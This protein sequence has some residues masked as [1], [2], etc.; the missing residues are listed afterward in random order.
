M[1]VPTLT[2]AEYIVLGMEPRN[3]LRF[4]HAKAVADVEKLSKETGFAVSP[5]AK[6]ADLSVGEAQRV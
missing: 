4:D 1:L 5:N 3:G 2:V 6:V